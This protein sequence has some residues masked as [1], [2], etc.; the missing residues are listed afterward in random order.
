MV[1]LLTS[2]TVLAAAL[3][4]S[5][6]ARADLMAYWSFDDGTGTVLTDNTLRGNDGELK[7]TTSF[8]TW[9][10]GHTGDPSDYSLE[11]YGSTVGS[12]SADSHVL[13]GNRADLQITG[14][15][16]ISMWLMPLNATAFSTYR[17]NPYAKAYG[18]EGTIT[19]ER[20]GTES[21]YYGDSGSTGGW[22]GFNSSPLTVSLD[23][24]NHILVVR[25]LTSS[26][27]TV[28]W[29]V[30]GVA[31][32]P[33]TTTKACVSGTRPVYIGRGYERN[34]YGRIDDSA[35]WN[36]ALDTAQAR[37]IYTVPTELGLDYQLSEV[38]ALWDIYASQGAGGIKGIPWQ[39]TDSLADLPTG[40]RPAPG[41]AYTGTD[42][43]MYVALGDGTGLAAV[44]EPSAFGLAALGLL[45]F[46]MCGRHRRRR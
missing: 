17:Q 33:T 24:W 38:M 40:G 42:G 22:V 35:V 31:K 27:N 43:I 46:A 21:Y 12:S 30:N 29:Y 13:V 37:S 6:S 32:A 45:G 16:T 44:P 23:Q 7:G 9:E 8:P 1:R 11:F 10:S 2:L 26:T 28:Q 39:Y 5:S 19:Q 14:D 15:Q 25:D 41:D 3:W 4:S 18:G 34:Y 36:E 20:G